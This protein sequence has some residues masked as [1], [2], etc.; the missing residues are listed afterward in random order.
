MT[1]LSETSSE[2]LRLQ[3]AAADEVGGVVAR[4]HEDAHED[5]T[6]VADPLDGWELPP[7][8]RRVCVLTQD[9]LAP[10]MAGPAIRALAIAEALAAEHDVVLASTQ[11]VQLS[12][13]GQLVRHVDDAG[14]RQ[15]EEWADVLVI[16]GF[17][18]QGHPWLRAT[19]KVLVADVYDPVHLEQLEQT[20]SW[21]VHL[22][23][24]TVAKGIAALQEQ[25]E[26][27]DFFLVAS[28]RQ[29]DFWLGWLSAAGRINPLT[30]GDDPTLR[31]LV[32]VVPFGVPDRPPLRG[33]RPL[34]GVFPGIGQQDTVLL[35]GGGLYNWLDPLTLIRAVDRL[36]HRRPRLRLVFLGTR[37][38]NPNVGEMDVAREARNLSDELGLTGDVVVFNERWVPYEERGDFLLDAD[39]GVTT[40]LD[41][42]ESAFAF[43]TRALDYL[44][45]GL[46]V[47]ATQ[48]DWLADLI[49]REDLGQTCV[50]G[51]VAS[52]VEALDQVLEPARMEVCRAN[53]ARVADLYR[54]SRVLLPLLEFCRDPRRAPDASGR[55]S[56]ALPVVAMPGLPL[57]PRELQSDVQLARALLKAGGPALVMAK[58]GSRLRRIRQSRR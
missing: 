23:E 47:V 9:V 24:Q 55:A 11:E 21:G 54:W 46:P 25:A 3:G 26:R 17:L 19:S 49:E 42:V 14:L 13:P 16:Q 2:P 57:R 31:R 33:A 56:L 40:H 34:R 37:H 8:R 22:R 58:V 36:R 12:R 29:R 20:R 44:W 45:A 39:V 32:G 38:P 30:Y 10:R 35:W 52:L 1:T 5:R 4:D 50:P 27:A 53:V 28:P 6:L 15:L 18:L 41:H 7:L 43:R 48:G 51:D